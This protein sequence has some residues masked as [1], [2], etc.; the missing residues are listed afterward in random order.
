M[1][2]GFKVWLS[3]LNVIEPPW[4]ARMDSDDWAFPD[5]F[6]F[7]M[8]YL[9]QHPH[10]TVLGT[11]AI[12]LEDQKPLHSHLPLSPGQ[13]AAAMPFYCCVCH[14]STILNRKQIIEEKLYPDFNHAEDY[15]LWLNLILN[16]QR[17]IVNL[18]NVLL[19]YRRG[20]SRPQYNEQQILSTIKI[21][22]IFDQNI[23][24][25]GTRPAFIENYDWDYVEHWFSDYH[26]KII[27]RLPYID[28]NLLMK[29]I[30]NQKRKAAK[31]IYRKDNLFLIRYLQQA[32]IDLFYKTL[33]RY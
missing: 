29:L 7:Q 6:K 28:K 33:Y 11:H 30:V 25:T 20:I 24:M 18:P 12:F 26:Q 10:T 13:V 4:V 21:K 19:K 3:T 9:E 23:G 22:K 14:P 27:K 16:P 17:R 8:E 1:D 2:S 15:G 31:A 5:R 32:S